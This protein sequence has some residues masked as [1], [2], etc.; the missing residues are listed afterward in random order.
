MILVEIEE[1]LK[2]RIDTLDQA[3]LD[4][5]NLLLEKYQK[6]ENEEKAN[7]CW[8]LKQIYIV[9]KEYLAA[10]HNL[11]KENFESAWYELERTEIELSFLESNFNIGNELNDPYSL[12]YIK[13]MVPRFQKLFPYKVFTSREALIKREVCSICGKEVKLRGGCT[14]KTGKL[15][16]GKMCSRIVKDITF[17]GAAIV[18][19][20]FDKYAVL[21]IEGQEFN[22][23]LIKY[24]S[25]H[26]NSPYDLWYYE[27]EQKIQPQYKALKRNEKC[28]CGS[29]KK[30]KRCC[31]NT[32]RIYRDHYKFSIIRRNHQT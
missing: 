12:V 23:D 25:G 7:Y 27:I 19:D 17:L 13:R 28:A 29:G 1:Y 24:I 18:A 15:Y 8:C 4:D 2:R 31:M 3:V 11:K 22:Y 9:K 30:Y 26:L 14:H 16:M 6:E 20:P 32:N 21:K 5:L 10:Y